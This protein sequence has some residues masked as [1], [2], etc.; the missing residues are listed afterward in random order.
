M[1]DSDAQSWNSVLWSIM[2]EDCKSYGDTILWYMEILQDMLL[3]RHIGANDNWVT[4]FGFGGVCLL[5]FLNLLHHHHASIRCQPDIP[6]TKFDSLCEF[7]AT[8][9]KSDEEEEPVKNLVS[10]RYCCII[11]PKLKTIVI[12]L[13][14]VIL[15]VDWTWLGS[16]VPCDMG[17]GG[18]QPCGGLVR[19]EYPRWLTSMAF[20]RELN[21]AYP[22]EHLCAS[23][24]IA[25]GIQRKHLKNNHSKRPRL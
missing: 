23:H 12:L 18:P 6:Y 20:S 14:L 21:G 25:F 8:P 19:L 10:V 4:L 7:K 1:D 15:W 11:S 24:C 5:P 16:S 22:L 3:E 17:T 9:V 13:S 2:W